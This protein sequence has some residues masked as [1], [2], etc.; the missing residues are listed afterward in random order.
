MDFDNFIAASAP[1]FAIM[2]AEAAAA[3]VVAARRLLRLALVTLPTVLPDSDFGLL[4]AEVGFGRTTDCFSCEAFF[5]CVFHSLP[6]IFFSETRSCRRGITK[7]YKTPLSS[8]PFGHA[9]GTGQ[10][11]FAHQCQNEHESK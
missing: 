8:H 9:S 3:A 10:E 7:P 2:S 1:S 5:G 11:A 4:D 6:V